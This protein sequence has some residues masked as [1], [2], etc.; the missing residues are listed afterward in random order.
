MFA[1][2]VRLQSLQKDNGIPFYASSNQFQVSLQ[3][4]LNCACTTVLA[5]KVH[6]RK[7]GNECPCC[8]EVY[9][10]GCKEDEIQLLI[11]KCEIM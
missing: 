5:H 6:V 3:S 7:R 4:C 8:P 9:T 10:T 1:L 2:L 11:S